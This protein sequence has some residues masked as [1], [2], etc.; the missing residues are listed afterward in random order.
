M[1]ANALTS[2]TLTACTRSWLV[3][4][5]RNDRQ[6]DPETLPLP[7]VPILAVPKAGL[8]SNHGNEAAGSAPQ[9]DDV[10]Q[11]RQFRVSIPFAPSFCSRMIVQ[12]VEK[13]AVCRPPPT[14]ILH[15]QHFLYFLPLPHGHGSFRP[16]L[17]VPRSESFLLTL[18]V[19]AIANRFFLLFERSRWRVLS[20][21]LWKPYLRPRSSPRTVHQAVP[22]GRS[23]R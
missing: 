22:C 19:L 16:T 1:V 5:L 20:V 15:S 17:L 12:T 4:R 23:D 8:A 21:L 7:T 10:K 9:V 11:P 18:L 2:P 3:A 6:R 13:A 14:L